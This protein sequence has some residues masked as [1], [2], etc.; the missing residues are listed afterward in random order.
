LEFIFPT[1]ASIRVA[2]EQAKRM[3]GYC[4]GAIFFR[5]PAWSESLTVHPDEALTAAGLLP[6]PIKKPPAIRV[7]D[8]RCA[9]VHCVDVYLLQDQPVTAQPAR[10]RVSGSTAFEYFLPNDN[11]A[12]RLTAPSELSLD[13][14]P[15]CGRR[16][17]L[18]GRAV[19]SK[20]VTFEVE[21]L[22]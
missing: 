15:F 4:A 8:G 16:R 3:G 19:T 9:A 14:P 17:T 6:A 1:V 21:V 5:W 13:V 22:P 20:P 10:Y 7:V 11:V 2:V 12:I 18:L